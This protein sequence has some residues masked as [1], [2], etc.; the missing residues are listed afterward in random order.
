MLSNMEEK[1]IIKKIKREVGLIFYFS[2]VNYL[3]PINI[4]M[5]TLFIKYIRVRLLSIIRL[6]L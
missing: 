4:Q 6:I 5:V 3:L 2:F 1:L